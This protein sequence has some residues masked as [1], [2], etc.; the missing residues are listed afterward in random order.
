M[1]QQTQVDTVIPYFQRFMRRFPKVEALANATQDEVLS[2]WSGLGYYAR[3]RNLLKAAQMIISEFDGKL[4]ADQCAL[5]SL[6]GIG[7]S[8]AGAILSLAFKQR[9]VILDGNVKRVLARY[10]VVDG[11]PGHTQ[12]ARTLWQHAEQHTPAIRC[13]AYTQAIMDLG[14]TVCTRSKPDCNRCPMQTHCKAFKLSD[15][16][17]ITPQTWPGKKPKKTKPKK[18][19]VFLILENHNEEILL[20]RRPQ[21]GIWGGLWSLPEMAENTDIATNIA[22]LYQLQL[23]S[24]QCWP[25]LKH[26]FTHFQLSI[27]PIHCKIEHMPGIKEI[28]TDSALWYK[29]EHTPPGGMPTPVM[30]L[31]AQ[32]QDNLNSRGTLNDTHG[33]LHRS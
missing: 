4:P 30:K 6:P 18:T 10:H 31:L 27:I 24:K 28:A 13:D 2:H 32:Y 26:Q 15:Q 14:A 22:S 33:T 20:L 9:A 5:E 1:L 3:A 8:T 12:V 11:W 7:R 23:I 16:G 29:T 19:S 25:T 17:D 21:T